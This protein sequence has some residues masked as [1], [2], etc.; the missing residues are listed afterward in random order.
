MPLIIYKIFEMLG[1][2]KGSIIPILNNKNKESQSHCT[3]NTNLSYTIETNQMKPESKFKREITDS[4]HHELNQL[5]F[6]RRGQR[7]S[8]SKFDEF[9]TKQLTRVGKYRFGKIS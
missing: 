1:P 8:D 3:E 5:E 7:F 2:K 9:T 6:K 4:K